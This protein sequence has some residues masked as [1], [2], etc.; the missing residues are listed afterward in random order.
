M[1]DNAI[2]RLQNGSDIRGVAITTENGERT[3]TRET[4]GA[5]GAAL[6]VYLKQ[7]LGK[8]KLRIAVGND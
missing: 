1:E 2:L 3:L 5:I 8:E 4:V 7:K 6:A